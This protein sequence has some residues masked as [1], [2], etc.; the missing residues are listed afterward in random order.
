MGELLVT[1]PEQRQKRLFAL[2]EEVPQD[3]IFHDGA[4]IAEDSWQLAPLR[5]DPV[6]WKLHSPLLGRRC[7]EGF[8]VKFPGLPLLEAERLGGAPFCVVDTV[9][10]ME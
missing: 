8:L 7:G 10:S 1:P 9:D 5:L 3:I 4:R 6:T 2:L